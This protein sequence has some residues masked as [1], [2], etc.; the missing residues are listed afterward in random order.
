[1]S[2][3]TVDFEPPVE[4]SNPP[5][6]APANFP[7]EPPATPEGGE[8]EK[9]SSFVLVGSPRYFEMMAQNEGREFQMTGLTYFTV[10]CDTLCELACHDCALGT[11]GKRKTG[12]SFDDRLERGRQILLSNTVRTRMPDIIEK[13][14]R[15]GTRQVVIIGNGEP[16]FQPKDDSIQPKS[17]D[18]IEGNDEPGFQEIMVPL[19]TTAHRFGLGTTMFTT[20]TY[21]TPQNSAI[22]R[23]NNVS[24]IVSLHSLNDENYLEIVRKGNPARARKNID[25][26][27]EIYKSDPAIESGDDDVTITRLGINFTLNQFNIGEVDDAREWAHRNGMQ[28]VANAKMLTGR[29]DTEKASETNFGADDPTDPEEIKRIFETH[30]AL[31]R[32]KSDTGGQSS[33]TSEHF[34]GFGRNGLSI[35]TDGTMMVCGYEGGTEAGLK[36][37]MPNILDLIKLSDEAIIEFSQ[38]MSDPELWGNLNSEC[39]TRAEKD[40]RVHFM[41]QLRARIVDFNERHGIKLLKDQIELSEEM[42]QRIQSRVKNGG[43]T[44]TTTPE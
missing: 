9:K 41:E 28:F 3:T 40:N 14:S 26:L 39:I 44:Q 7:E 8:N 12:D 6:E 19:M 1:M 16:T 33:I 11:I 30:R 23:D 2:E 18:Y 15:L 10:N 31:A 36:D 27:I 13:L 37:V 35:N 25:E 21:L 24:P 4:I 17:D 34:C 38:I 20:A 42:Q 5:E 43:E 29:G 22:L 32:T